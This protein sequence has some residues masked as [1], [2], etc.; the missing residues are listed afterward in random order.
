MLGDSFGIGKRPV[1]NRKAGE[2]GLSKYAYSLGSGL[3]YGFG[4]FFEHQLD[5]ILIVHVYGYFAALH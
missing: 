1:A 4:L 2:A 5:L 3:E